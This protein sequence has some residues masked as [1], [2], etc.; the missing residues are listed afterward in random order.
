MSQERGEEDQGMV[1]LSCNL[2]QITAHA[3]RGSSSYSRTEQIVRDSATL[4]RS[5]RISSRYSQEPE[6][7][8]LHFTVSSRRTIRERTPILDESSGQSVPSLFD[9]RDADV[10]DNPRHLYGKE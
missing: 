2:F 5:P 9:E 4:R 6:P 1:M 8:Q 3:Y 10:A 7:H